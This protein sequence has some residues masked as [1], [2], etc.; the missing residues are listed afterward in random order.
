[1]GFQSILPISTPPMVR[2]TSHF[3]PQDKKT[4]TVVSSKFHKTILTSSYGRGFRENSALGT[5][6]DRTLGVA[7]F[8]TRKRQVL[9]IFRKTTQSEAHTHQEDIY[10]AKPPAARDISMLTLNA[11]WLQTKRTFE[12]P[13]LWRGSVSEEP[14]LAVQV[15]IAAQS[16]AELRSL[17]EV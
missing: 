15:A 1:M 13:K 5:P 2:Y 17:R 12:T 14:K 10:S 11:E 4:A 16:A 6:T 8:C 7:H 9:R 3:R